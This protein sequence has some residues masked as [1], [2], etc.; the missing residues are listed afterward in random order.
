M[1]V[2]G[3]GRDRPYLP[4]LR[5]GCVLT[6]LTTSVAKLDCAIVPGLSGAAATGNTSTDELPA[7]LGI[8]SANVHD[9][10]GMKIG[11]GLV[12]RV[13]PKLEKLRSLLP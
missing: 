11:E 8:I 2:A 1:I 12:V 4:S 5:E 7:L 3:Y 10:T 9:P 13:K 6:P